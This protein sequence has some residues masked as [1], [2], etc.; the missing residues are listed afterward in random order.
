MWGAKEGIL[1]DM[2]S[3]IKDYEKKSYWQIDQNFL[4]EVIFPKIEDD[5]FV[6]D[7]FGEGNLI[8]KARK[9]FEF[10]GDVFDE[11]DTRDDLLWREIQK[12]RILRRKNESF[13][14]ILLMTWKKMKTTW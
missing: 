14:K 7:E 13:K 1:L 6:H 11:N 4:A 2:R 10:I 5:V 12:E 8:K 3:L 9:N